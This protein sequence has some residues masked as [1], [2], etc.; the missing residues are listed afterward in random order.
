[1]TPAEANA[2]LQSLAKLWE[3]CPE[4]RFGQLMATLGLLA[5]DA[6]DHSLWDVEDEELLAVMEQ[7]REK[8]AR[9]GQSSASQG[10]AP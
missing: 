8:L 6:T 10:A 5:E 9:R 1:M 4:M 2:M 7:F 3:L